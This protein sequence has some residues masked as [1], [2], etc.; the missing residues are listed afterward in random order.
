VCD[1]AYVLLVEQ[2]ERR[3]LA[4]RQALVARGVSED[5]PTPGVEQARFDEFLTS[6]QRRPEAMTE[7]EIA[8]NEELTA[9]GVA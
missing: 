8:R 3:V 6:E 7:A 9:L 1:V 5:L 2:L 4:D